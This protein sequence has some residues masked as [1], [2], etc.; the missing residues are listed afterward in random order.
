M[1]EDCLEFDFDNSTF[2][3]TVTSE[4]LVRTQRFAVRSGLKYCAF[5]GITVDEDKIIKSANNRFDLFNSTI[6]RVTEHTSGSPTRVYTC[7]VSS[8]EH[9]SMVTLQI[10]M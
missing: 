2:S 8:W 5:F 3:S 7:L 6:W 4:V 1:V 10:S 9:L